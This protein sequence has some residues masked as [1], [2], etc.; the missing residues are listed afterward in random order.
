ML[1]I[2]HEDYRTDLLA[3]MARQ[4]VS[5]EEQAARLPQQTF[6]DRMTLYHGGKEIQILHV[7]RAHT[8]GGSIISSPAGFRSR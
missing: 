6:R 3:L 1:K 8:R 5:A 2:G 7:G 4:K